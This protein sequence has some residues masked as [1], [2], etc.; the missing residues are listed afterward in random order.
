MTFNIIDN[1]GRLRVTEL[2]WL[3]A[4]QMLIELVNDHDGAYSAFLYERNKTNG[5]RTAH[6]FNNGIEWGYSIKKVEKSL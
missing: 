5:V 4:R 6:G 3:R 2:T 1:H